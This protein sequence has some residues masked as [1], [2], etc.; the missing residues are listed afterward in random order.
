MIQN[1]IPRRAAS[2][3]APKNGREPQNL[4][5][6]LPISSPPNNP[7]LSRSLPTSTGDIHN[8]AR[9]IPSICLKCRSFATPNR[10]SVPRHNPFFTFY[11]PRYSPS[12][13]N[14]ITFDDCNL[15]RFIVNRVGE[16]LLRFYGTLRWEMC[17]F[18]P[19]IQFFFLPRERDAHLT[20][21]KLLFELLLYFYRIIP[22]FL[23]KKLIKLR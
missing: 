3:R 14:K 23:Q 22:L 16:F 5:N 15:S 18:Y 6:P 11:M 1:S 20:P 12:F 4:F 17:F 7:S 19:R 8:T 2:F 10:V 9:S 13:F 21:G